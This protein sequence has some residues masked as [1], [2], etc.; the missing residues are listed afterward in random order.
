MISDRFPVRVVVLALALGFLGS[1]A[2]IAYL[3]FTGTTIP[4][5][6]SDLPLWSGGALAG[7]L[8]QTG[9]RDS[10]SVT[11]DQPAND[12]IPTTV[13]PSPTP[14]TTDDSTT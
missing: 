5:S 7:L 13:S 14:D 3:A 8:A 11:I 1:I 2:A 4:D 10:S 9:S 6:L 12:P